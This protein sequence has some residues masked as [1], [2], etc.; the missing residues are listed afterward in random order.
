MLWGA[1]HPRLRCYYICWSRKQRIAAANKTVSALCCG[2][3]WMHISK[4]HYRKPIDEEWHI[5]WS[6]GMTLWSVK[7]RATFST[8][9][10]TT[11]Q[12]S[13]QDTRGFSQSHS[14]SRFSLRWCRG[15]QPPSYAVR[16]GGLEARSA[17]LSFSLSRS[18]FLPRS[19]GHGFRETA[20]MSKA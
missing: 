5:T 2:C 11:S 10:E 9:F 19:S 13:H 17:S 3:N 4:R 14:K 8:P 7:L 6:P 12:I 20:A 15:L 1:I 18:F 16:R